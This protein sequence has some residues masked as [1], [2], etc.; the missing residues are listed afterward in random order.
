MKKENYRV[1]MRHPLTGEGGEGQPG[2]AVRA[3]EPDKGVR[4]TEL[5]NEGK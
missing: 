5:N 3:G 2:A 4:W 1:G